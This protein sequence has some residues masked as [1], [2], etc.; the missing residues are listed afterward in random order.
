M[1]KIQNIILTMGAILSVGLATLPVTVGAVD[2]FPQC[3]GSNTSAVCKSTN[4]DLS[5][6]IRTIVNTLLYIL[7]AVS[8]LVIVIAGIMYVVSGGDL[9]AVNKAKNAL[10]YAV[11]GLIVAILAYAIVN[12]VITRVSP[13]VAENAAVLTK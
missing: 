2:V 13:V 9:N 7:G 6:M 12:F 8:V 5:S 11:I 1:K 3:D 10:L 4:D